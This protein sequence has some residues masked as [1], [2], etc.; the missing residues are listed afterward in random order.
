MLLP[1]G[2][3]A[4]AVLCLIT[5][6]IKIYWG[7]KDKIAALFKTIVYEISARKN[8]E[9]FAERVIKIM[10]RNRY[11]PV[12]NPIILDINGPDESK[13]AYYVIR[14]EIIFLLK[15]IDFIQGQKNYLTE[16]T[17]KEQLEKS[18]SLAE[19]KKRLMVMDVISEYVPIE[20]EMY[21]LQKIYNE[22]VRLYITLPDKNNYQ[23]FNFKPLF[24][25]MD[26]LPGKDIL[27][28]PHTLK[29]I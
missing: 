21:D 17:P 15:N 10:R 29:T 16:L 28:F 18:L 26:K 13:I 14:A 19:Y 7:R 12:I 2:F 9:Q 6:C 20:D 3:F 25:I 27:I 22:T 5:L 8:P 4:C 24:Y 11:I 23:A 1:L